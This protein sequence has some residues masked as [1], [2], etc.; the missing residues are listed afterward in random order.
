MKHKLFQVFPGGSDGKEST[1]VAGDLGLI[2][3]MGRSTA[4]RQAEYLNTPVFLP[5]ESRTPI[6]RGAWQI[7]LHGAT[8]SLT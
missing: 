5:G 3:V 2:P 4:G 6:D 7:I 1:R 8:E